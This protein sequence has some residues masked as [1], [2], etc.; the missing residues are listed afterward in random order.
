[1]TAAWSPDELQRIGAAQ[2][3]HIA[4]NRADGTLQRA[5]PIWVVVVDHEIYVRTWYRR[6]TGW[7]AHAVD[8]RLGRIVV[9]GVEADVTVEDIGADDAS[10]R[11]GIDA[12]Y[13][14]K[15]GHGGDGSVDRMVN[16]DAA[17]ATLRLVRRAYPPA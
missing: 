7:F 4:I 13:R 10:V 6:D 12:A 8:I 15:Y 11:A 17:A 5:V 1:M 9:P 16:D 2:E 14:A 3:L